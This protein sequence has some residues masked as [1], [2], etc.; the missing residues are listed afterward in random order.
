MI[1]KALFSSVLGEEN[2]SW[3]RSDGALMEGEAGLPGDVNLE[4]YPCNY[5]MSEV[6][7][8]EQVES[9]MS[10]GPLRQAPAARRRRSEALVCLE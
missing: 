3:V 6:S 8:L 7:R 4:R 5:C 10:G 1:T 9:Q 2:S